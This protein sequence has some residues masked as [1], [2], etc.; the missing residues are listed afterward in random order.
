MSLD[1]E[2]VRELC[3]KGLT[4]VQIA[5]RLG[6]TRRAVEAACK[7]HSIPVAVVAGYE[8]RAASVKSACSPIEISWSPN[9]K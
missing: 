3:A 4:R 2:R 5:E 7:R 9:V 6:A 1:I 8:S